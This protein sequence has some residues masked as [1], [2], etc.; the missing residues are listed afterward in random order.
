[1]NLAEKYRAADGWKKNLGGD[2]FNPTNRT[3]EFVLEDGTFG[4][5]KSSVKLDWSTAKGDQSIAYYRFQPSDD[6]PEERIGVI[7]QNGG[8]GEHYSALYKQEGGNHYKD[9][10]IQPIEFIVENDLPF[11]EAN[12]IKYIC[13]HYQKNGADDIRK[14]IHYLEMILETEYESVD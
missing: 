8:D 9:M 2:K 12:A 4:V 10:V 11:R 7:G 5:S 13:R 3:V 14:A 1:M 6:W